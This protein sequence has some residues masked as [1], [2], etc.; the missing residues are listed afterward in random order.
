VRSTR[1]P[2]L[3]PRGRFRRTPRLQLRATIESR[4]QTGTEDST[5]AATTHRRKSAGCCD[6]DSG[7]PWEANLSAANIH[8][9]CP[10]GVSQTHRC[11]VMQL[12]H[13]RTTPISKKPK[14]TI[15]FNLQRLNRPSVEAAIATHSSQKRDSN[16]SNQLAQLG[17][18]T[19]VGQ[20][21]RNR[22]RRSCCLVKIGFLTAGRRAGHHCR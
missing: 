6:G 16:I 2:P 8:I 1:A 19:G 17:K 21:C 11:I 20:K 5:L 7:K 13:L 14:R 15:G 22:A 9:F 10:I 18:V 3:R 12:V 4:G